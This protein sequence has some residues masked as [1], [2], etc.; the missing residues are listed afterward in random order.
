MSNQNPVRV[1]PEEVQSEVSR[2]FKTPEQFR[3]DAGV[4][5]WRWLLRN[6]NWMPIA[7]REDVVCIPREV[8][9]TLLTRHDPKNTTVHCIHG[10][11][12]SICCH[13]KAPTEVV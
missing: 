5:E 8:A 10:L 9:E 3:N 12:P 11:S 4:L 6:I 7:G 1:I 13:E 2:H